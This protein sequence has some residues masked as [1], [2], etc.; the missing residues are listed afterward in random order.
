M[1]LCSLVHRKTDSLSFV[2][3]ETT[4]IKMACLL[5]VCACVCQAILTDVPRLQHIIVVD[6]APT[7]WPGYPRGI[8]IHNMAAV[9]KLG[10]RHENG[11][12][13]LCVCSLIYVKFAFKSS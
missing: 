11:R 8:S 7:A 10:A 12:F 5:C 1:F 9:Q 13:C 2:N 3:I 4:Y 6:N